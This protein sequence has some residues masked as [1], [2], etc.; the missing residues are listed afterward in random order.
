MA[1]YVKVLG[2]Y[3]R[4]EEWATVEFGDRRFQ[5]RE[6]IND[7]LAPYFDGLSFAEVKIVRRLSPEEM[8][9]AVRDTYNCG[10]L[11]EA[12]QVAL[13]RAYLEVLSSLCERDG[14]MLVRH[15]LLTFRATAK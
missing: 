3:A 4:R 5:S 8:W 13:Q 6:G 2:Q 9:L 7:L 10:L 11:S 14:K 15:A 1:E 12:D